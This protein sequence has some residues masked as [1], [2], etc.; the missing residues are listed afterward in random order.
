MAKDE[1]KAK[2]LIL[3]AA[4]SGDH[5]A[6]TCYAE[7]ILQEEGKKLNAKSGADQAPLD[8]NN[9]EVVRALELLHRA[10][11]SG[12]P[13]AMMRL[14]GMYERGMKYVCLYVNRLI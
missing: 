12:E 6:E 10:C 11:K 4:E 13:D 14:A 1:S 9:P 2:A 7:I 3:E 5:F 8:S